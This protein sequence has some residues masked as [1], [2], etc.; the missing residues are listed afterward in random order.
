MDDCTFAQLG[1]VVPVWSLPGAP[2]W[3]SP[4]GLA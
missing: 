3:N 4:V 1:S 2:D